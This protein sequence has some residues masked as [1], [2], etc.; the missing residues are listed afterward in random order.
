MPLATAIYSGNIFQFMKSEQLMAG[1]DSEPEKNEFRIGGNTFYDRKNKIPM[2]IPE[3]KRSKIEII[4]EFCGIPNGF[5]NLATT[6][7]SDLAIPA[8]PTRFLLLSENLIRESIEIRARA[9]RRCFF[10]HLILYLCS[11]KILI[12]LKLTIFCF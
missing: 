8:I 4:A 10:E 1:E 3:S 6:W 11:L 2:K 12:K 9:L 5:P 7:R